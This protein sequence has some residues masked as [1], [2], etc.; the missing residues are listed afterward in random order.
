MCVRSRSLA[1]S[2]IANGD[3]FTAERPVASTQDAKEAG[4]TDESEQN[5]A[6]VL[7]KNQQKRLAKRAKFVEQRQARKQNRKAQVIALAICNRLA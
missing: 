1:C 4:A 3:E 2:N 5:D 7:S 6:P